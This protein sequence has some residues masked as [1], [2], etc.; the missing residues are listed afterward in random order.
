MYYNF[1]LKHFLIKA[2]I[3]KVVSKRLFTLNGYADDST[4]VAV[5]PSWRESSGHRVPES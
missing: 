1:Y 3:K 5:D 4:G 2:I